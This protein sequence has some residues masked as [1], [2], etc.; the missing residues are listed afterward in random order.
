MQLQEH[1]RQHLARDMKERRVREH[2][3][4]ALVWQCEPQEI[5]VPDFAAAVG[6]G[7]HYETLSTIYAHRFVPQLC[8]RL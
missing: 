8:K 7:H 1:T 3:I 4:K 5:L 6:P 2:T